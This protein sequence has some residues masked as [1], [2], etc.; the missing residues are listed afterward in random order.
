MRIDYGFYTDSFGGGDV[1]ES[2][3]KRFMQKA[4]SRLEHYTFGRMPED[5]SGE[6][7]ENKA[8]C[9]ICEMVEAMYA[10][11]TRTGKTSENNDGYSVS[12][13]TSKSIDSILYEIAK[14]YL[15]NT[16]LMD[17]EVV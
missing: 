10:D 15:A 1:P 2:V 8:K 13:D 3:W 5:W 6:P 4:A 17:F 12:Y 7:W 14:V 16:G 9:A 11:S